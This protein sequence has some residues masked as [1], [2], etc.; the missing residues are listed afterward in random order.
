MGLI[1]P[2]IVNTPC[3]ADIFFEDVRN[4]KLTNLKK[5][6]GL[7]QILLKMLK[8]AGSV[9]EGD[10]SLTSNKLITDKRFVRVKTT[11]TLTLVF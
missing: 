6:E 11:Y 4:V 3:F 2:K 8:E 10:F 1:L 9:L 7:L 5:T